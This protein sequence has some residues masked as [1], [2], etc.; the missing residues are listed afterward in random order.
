MDIFFSFFSSLYPSIVY[1]VAL[2][3]SSHSNPSIDLLISSTPSPAQPAIK[4]VSPSNEKSKPIPYPSPLRPHRSDASRSLSLNVPSTPART[5]PLTN[6]GRG[7]LVKDSTSAYSMKAE[8]DQVTATPESM[9]T[10]VGVGP[11]NGN[12]Y[13][14]QSRAYS[15]SVYDRPQQMEM[16]RRFEKRD[17]KDTTQ[18]EFYFLTLLAISGWPSCLHVNKS[19]LS[20]TMRTKSVQRT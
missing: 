4:M 15:P 6:V 16:E 9:R 3:S 17:G 5:V 13:N 2:Q 11:G 7:E 18:S 14:D 10:V 19:I 1:L 8:D 12:V 20:T